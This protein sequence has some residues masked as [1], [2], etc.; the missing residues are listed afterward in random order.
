MKNNI[1]KK[2]SALAMVPIIGATASSCSKRDLVDV[3]VDNCASIYNDTFVKESEFEYE[4]LEDKIPYNLNGNKLVFVRRYDQFDGA[5]KWYCGYLTYNEET[6]YIYD[7]INN[8]KIDL[9]TQLGYDYEFTYVIAE[10]LQLYNYD[11]NSTNS[12]P[13]KDIKKLLDSSFIRARNVTKLYFIEPNTKKELSVNMYDLEWS[14]LTNL[15]NY[16]KT[17]TTTRVLKK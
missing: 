17:K 14:I 6:A 11:L 8:E 15:D 10:E 12:I 9:Y 2:V 13:K 4:I 1:L 16:T 3:Y 5:V 7:V